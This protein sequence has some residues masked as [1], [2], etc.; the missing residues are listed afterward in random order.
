MRD[1]EIAVQYTLSPDEA[2]A[3]R[4]GA[5][6]I[7][8]SSPRPADPEFYDR[9]WDIHL[10]LPGGLRR[11]L[12]EF[13]R[14]ESAAVCLVHGFGV[15]DDAVGATPGHW[16]SAIGSTAAVEQEI[17]MA[18]CAM[19]LG[20]P[21][22]WST[23]Q[24]GMMIQNIFPIR[25]D[26]VRQNG[27]S[28]DTLLEFHTEDG[29]HPLRCD[30]LLLFGLRNHDRVPTIVSSVRDVALSEQDTR[31]LSEPRFLIVP[32]DEHIRQ[33]ELRHPGHPALAK[34]LQIRDRPQPVPV[35]F[36]TTFSPYLRI[37]R[38]FMRCVGDDPVAER[39]LDRLMDELRRVQYSV[40]VNPG[41]LAVVDNYL[42]VHGRKPFAGRY[43]GTDRWL[44][45][46]IVSRDIRKSA[47]H[48]ATSSRRVLY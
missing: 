44:K 47:D 6:E 12:E 31:I 18:M 2:A 39:A 38:P 5:R 21:F 42:A 48:R 9:H 36:G 41:T 26:E 37:D 35:L 25:G 22:T 10:M 29:F 19:A 17:A 46:M 20:E 15:D 28:S 43:D 13:R 23:L 30:Y 7:A 40:V 34:M 14:T 32:D 27:H 16:E 3:V 45:R 8:R 11:F 24:A 33:L 1:E 4:A